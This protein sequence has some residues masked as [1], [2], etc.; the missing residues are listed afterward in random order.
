LET[1]SARHIGLHKT[2]YLSGGKKQSVDA[3]AT[4]ASNALSMFDHSSEH[5]FFPE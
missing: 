1:L 2:L 5:H 4:D 3:C